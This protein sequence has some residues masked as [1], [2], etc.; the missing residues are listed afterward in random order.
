MIIGLVP[1]Q[2]AGDSIDILPM[3][4]ALAPAG[5]AD[6]WAEFQEKVKSDPEQG[7]KML[8]E[9]RA[10][11]IC[12]DCPTFN[13]CAKQKGELFF[14]SIYSARSGCITKEKWCICETCPVTE[15]EGLTK[16]YYCIKGNETEQR[17]SL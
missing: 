13:D 1:T 11:C 8:E 3:S 14:C 16:T 12:P 4:M 6:R 9:H 15:L 2:S 7:K 17:G 5:R 10:K